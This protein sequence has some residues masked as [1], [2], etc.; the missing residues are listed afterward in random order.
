MNKASRVAT[1]S[2]DK[3]RSSVP[4]GGLPRVSH[5]DCSDSL[6]YLNKGF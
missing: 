2:P 1:L 5:V 4:L 6:L 3:C